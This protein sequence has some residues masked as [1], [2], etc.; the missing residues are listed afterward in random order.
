MED[1]IFCKIINKEISNYTVHEDKNS[2]AFLD[3]NPCCQGHTV[4]IP[5][6]HVETPFSM[7]HKDFLELFK[8]VKNTMEVID[9]VLHPDGYNVGWNQM[10]AG[11]QVVPHIHI[12]IMP[13]WKEDGGGSMHTIIKNSGPTPVEDVAKL[14]D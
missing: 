10:S 13:R 8:S 9:R 3:I 6:N 2:L 7:S 11:G 5:K 14:F 1:C 12:H 4:V